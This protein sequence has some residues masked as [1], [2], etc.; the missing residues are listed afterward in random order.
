M[1]MLEII[2]TVT[3]A[4]TIMDMEETTTRLVVEMI[5]MAIM[6]GQLVPII[7]PLLVNQKK[8]EREMISTL[9]AVVI[10][11]WLLEQLIIPLLVN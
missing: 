10:M 11:Y 7:L 6:T 1:D 3:Q 2:L 8:R 9:G 4:T 5:L